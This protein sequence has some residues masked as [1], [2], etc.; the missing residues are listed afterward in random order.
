M[1]QNPTSEKDPLI[2]AIKEEHIEVMPEGKVNVHIGIINHSII[3][4]YFDILVKGIPPEWVTIDTPVVYLA[5]GEAKQVILTIQPPTLLQSRVGQY[6]LDVHAISQGNPPHSAVAHSSLTVAAYH[7]QGRIAVA[8]ASIYFSVAPGLSV[9]I[10]VLLQN[11]GTREDSFQLSIEGIP[12]SWISTNAVYTRLEPFKSQE[13]EFTINV[14]HS[15]EAGVGRQP[16]KIVFVSQLFP[17]QK[18]EVECILTVAA[19]SKFSAWLQP[20]VLQHDKTGH[21]LIHNEG[22]TGD[23]YTLNF[24]SPAGVLIFERGTQVSKTLTQSGAQH[25]QTAY[26][27][28]PPDERIHVAA[29]GQGMY[30][31]RGN[32]RSRPLVGEE[33][34]YPFTV[35]VLSAENTVTDLSGEVKEKGYIHP[36]VAGAMI[37]IPL[38]ACLLFV[39][40]FL[41]SMN[42]AQAAAR[43]ATETAVV[44]QTQT[45]APLTPSG[46][47]DSDGDGLIDSDEIAAGT[48]LFKPDTDSDELLDSQEI[49]I[50]KTNP[51][52]SDTDQDGLSDGAEA[53]RQKTSPL[54]AD[55]DGDSLKDGDEVTRKTDPLNQ[56]TDRDGL[57]DGVEVS[58]GS[59][60]LQMDSDQDGLMDGQENQTCP[61]ILAPDS[62]GDGTLDGK[63][64]EPCNQLN[65]LWT[66]T[67][68]AAAL[69]QS[70]PPATAIPPTNVQP[71]NIPPTNVPPTAVP[72][73]QTSIPP[74]NTLVP[75]TNTV[76][77][78]PTATRVF[79]PVQG[80]MVFASNRDGNPEI[81]ALNLSNRSLLRLTNNATVDM[82]PALAP[83]GVRVAY[84]SNQNG[85][86]EI[87]LT[88]LNREP[89]VNLT[90]NPG[91]DQQPSWSPDGK[92]IAF[93]SNRDGNQEIYVMSS[94]GS[95]VRN[96]TSNPAS[97]FAPTWF[98]IP[99]FLSLGTEEWI[100]FTSNRD[101]NQEIYRIRP[102]GT[103]LVNLT[104]NQSNDYAPTGSVAGSLSFVTDRDGNPEIYTMT[105]DGGSPVNLTNSFSQDLDPVFNSDGKWLAY[106]SDRDGNQEIYV[107]DLMTG[108]AYNIT[109]NPAQDVLPDW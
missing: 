108:L 106:S 78:P 81:Y 26:A 21:L 34:A 89:P 54:N 42:G 64:L 17:D 60:P 72:P 109:G 65:P 15:H 46:S 102:A 97:D 9:T 56:D 37:I 30:S 79:P 50:S 22:N 1:S 98:T 16:F 105:S 43:H 32:L 90:N 87:Y 85:N 95:E 19:F 27:E 96:L 83:D 88:G 25:I 11:H 4:D 48:D 73:T 31:F 68:L 62:D 51:L 74:T 47:G 80:V 77:V 12:A 53:L 33:R 69:T 92:W 38:L 93:T 14:P 36:S 3:D 10:P 67:A 71:T 49:T 57:G 75:P 70:P 94:S 91:D 61:R 5:T 59:D 13:V 8:L 7:S 40:P 39:A 76:V 86:N 29:G 44:A 103:G 6:P 100:A 55:T 41:V 23:T 66:A 52:V 99:G 107:I 104:K 24:H 101:G 63:D 82:H 28:I 35:Q 2:L 84:V 58:F 45:T 20:R 18:T